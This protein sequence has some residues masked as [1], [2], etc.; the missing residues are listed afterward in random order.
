M[1]WLIALFIRH[2]Y[3][4]AIGR[5]SLLPVGEVKINIYIYDYLS[6][7]LFEKRIMFLNRNINM[8]C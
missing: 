4:M 2:S 5:R 8:S 1:K 7:E 3:P 6:L